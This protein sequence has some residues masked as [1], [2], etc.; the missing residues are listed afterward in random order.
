[1]TFNR[2]SLRPFAL[3]AACFSMFLSMSGTAMAAPGT[4]VVISQVY[5]GG[6]NSGATYTNDF[7]EIFNPTQATVSLAG[8]S[9]QYA[10]STGSSWQTTPLPSISLQPGEYALIEEAVGAAGT[11]PLPTGCSTTNPTTTA[12]YNCPSGLGVTNKT[13]GSPRQIQMTLQFNF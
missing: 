11:T 8:W 12:F 1:M 13:I 10:S 6:G 7:I 4:S 9:V 5:G 3:L 2:F